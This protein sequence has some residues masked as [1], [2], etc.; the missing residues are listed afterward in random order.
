MLQNTV[1]HLRAANAPARAQ[2][3]HVTKRT[4]ILLRRLGSCTRQHCIEATASGSP[5]SGYLNH[6]VTWVSE[7][8]MRYFTLECVYTNTHSLHLHKIP[9]CLQLVVFTH[10]QV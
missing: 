9:L 5:H 6:T 8:L 2:T 7:L 1:E 4:C 3:Y 10:Y